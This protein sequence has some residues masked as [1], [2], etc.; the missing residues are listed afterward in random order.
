MLQFCRK[1]SLLAIGSILMVMGVAACG[2]LAA[3]APPLGRA[4]VLVVD[5]ASNVG[6]GNVLMTL[7]TTSGTAWAQL[8]TSADGTGEFRSGDGGV[9]IQGYKVRME[10]PTGYS[11]A[12]GETND[13]P[14]TVVIG[15]T[16]TTTF[17]LHRGTVAPPPGG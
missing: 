15:Q 11:L 16:T 13:K 10:I 9:I 1:G 4:T 12:N 3:P 6:V 7:F 2:N 5:S 14:L 17:K 8:R